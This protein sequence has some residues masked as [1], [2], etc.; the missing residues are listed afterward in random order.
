MNSE[1]FGACGLRWRQEAQEAQS[2][3]ERRVCSIIAEGYERLAQI[4]AHQDLNSGDFPVTP[5]RG[6][7]YLIDFR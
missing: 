7:E 4:L 5:R 3:E 2:E 1:R 6:F